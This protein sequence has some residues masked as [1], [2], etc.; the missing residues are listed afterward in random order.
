MPKII[1]YQQNISFPIKQK[2]QVIE[3]LFDENKTNITLQ[4]YTQKAIMFINTE[5]DNHLLN[6]AINHLMANQFTVCLNKAL[7]TG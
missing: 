1:Y 2:K 6:F 4:I 7:N 3:L 5:S